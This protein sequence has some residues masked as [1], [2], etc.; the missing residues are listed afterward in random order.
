MMFGAPSAFEY[1]EMDPSLTAE[2]GGGEG[3]TP[4]GFVTTY[5][6][7]NSNTIP[8]GGSSTASADSL[9][10]APQLICNLN[11][12]QGAILNYIVPSM[13]SSASNLLDEEE[14]IAQAATSFIQG[15]FQEGGPKSPNRSFSKLSVARNSSTPDT[16]FADLA[17]RGVVLSKEI[18]C[19]TSVEAWT[20]VPASSVPL[21]F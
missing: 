1:G 6:D 4:D 21:S 7:N 3:S 14:A 15:G 12:K 8:S 17:A 10:H 11:G 16:T 2:E 19:G 13:F 18:V 20:R 9:P 5:P